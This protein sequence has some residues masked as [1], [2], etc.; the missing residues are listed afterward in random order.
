[1]QL[2]LNSE[3]QELR[4]VVGK[5][6]AEHAPPDRIRQI[7]DTPEGFDRELWHRMAGELGLAGLVVPEEHGGSGSGNVER[8]VVAEEL[9][10]ALL[11]TPF[12]ASAVL[13]ADAL[14]ALDDSEAQAEL[15]PELVSGRLVAA[16]AG[17]VL[18][19][20]DDVTASWRGGTWLLEGRTAPVVLGGVAD[21]VLVHAR[22]DRGSGWFLVSGGASGLTRTPLRTLDPTRKLARLDFSSAPAR[23]LHAEDAAGTLSKVNDLAVVALLAEGV[24][25]MQRAL[26]MTVDYAKVR[27]QFGRAIGSYQAVKHSCADMYCACEQ[28]LSVVR[29]AA[30]VADNDP[31]QLPLAAASAQVFVSPAYFRAASDTVQLHGGIGYTW[32]HDAHFHLKRAKASELLLGT[33]AQHRVRVAALAGIGEN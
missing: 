23:L 6:V 3:Q 27:V 4:S 24:G 32:E 33:T 26:E 22:T 1:M 29:H 18:G 8:C 2:V 15:L 10:R 12:L 7:M 9:G 19:S 30:W 21:V 16:V 14:L 17:G 11:P 31:E 5:F 25:G 28:A 20:S 13:A